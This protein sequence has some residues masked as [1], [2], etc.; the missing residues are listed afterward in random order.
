MGEGRLGRALRR[1]TVSSSYKS[2]PGDP[3]SRGI[4]DTGRG[5]DWG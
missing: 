4:E 5:W 2:E 1:G 3:P